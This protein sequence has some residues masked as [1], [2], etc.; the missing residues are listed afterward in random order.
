MGSSSASAMSMAATAVSS[1]M[2]MATGSAMA[3]ASGT[4]TAAAASATSSA[5]AM[6]MSMGGSG[7]SCKI[8]M[9]WNW[10]TINSCFL[11][12]SWHVTTRGQFAG[13]CIGVVC[14]GVLVELVRRLQREYDRYLLRTFAMRN[15][16]MRA[17]ASAGSDDSLAATKNNLPAIQYVLQD[18]IF[19]TLRSNPNALHYTP[20][21]LAQAVRAGLYLLQ[22]AGAYFIMLFAMYYNGYVIICIFIGGFLGNFLFGGDTFKPAHSGEFGE[23]APSKTCC[24]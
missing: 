11:A 15:N 8:S 4:A 3:M 10:Y 23:V 19:P 6:S 22:Y 20:S 17:A 14:I 24:C 2:S 7:S 5:A 9:L 16:A 12:R 13:T 21:I 1:A 18:P